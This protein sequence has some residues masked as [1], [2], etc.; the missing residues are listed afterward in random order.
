MKQLAIIVLITLFLAGLGLL[1]GGR[2]LAMDQFVWSFDEVVR[3]AAGDNTGNQ[4]PEPIQEEVTYQTEPEPEPALRPEADQPLAEEPQPWPATN[5]QN[6][7]LTTSSND[8][9][10]DYYWLPSPEPRPRPGH[11]TWDFCG[12]HPPG[13][14]NWIDDCDGDDIFL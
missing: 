13:Y 3:V 11:W 12:F 9:D 6:H 1:V 14:F 7:S 8:A 10:R 5:E 2:G 4:P